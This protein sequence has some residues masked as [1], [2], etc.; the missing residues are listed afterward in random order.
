MTDVKGKKVL[1]MGL[2]RFGGGVGVTK[3]LVQKG[4]HVTITDL[5]TAQ[6]LSESVQ[7]LKGLKLKWVLGQHDSRDVK[8]ADL[9]VVNPA[10]KPDSPYLK[11]ASKWRV[12]ITTEI[13]LFLERCSARVVGVTGTNGK[14]TVARMIYSILA[15]NKKQVTGNRKVWLGGNIGKSLLPEL[16]KIK[17]NDIVV[18]ELS[19]FQLA[20]LPIIKKSP[21][22]TVIVNITPDHLDWHKTM[23]AY[24][25]AKRNILWFQDRNDFTVLNWRDKNVRKVAKGAKSNLVKIFR[26]VSGLKLKVQGEHN[27]MNATLAAEVGR[28]FG[29]QMSEIRNQLAH[30]SGVEYA[31]EFVGQRNGV[32]FY[33]DSAAT[34]PEATIAALNSFEQPVILI[35]GGYDKKINLKPFSRQIKHKF[36]ALLL[37]GQTGHALH[38]MVRGSVHTST[39]DRA[40]SL[41]KQLAKPGD[42]ILLSPAAAS[43]DQFENLEERGRRFKNLV[44][45]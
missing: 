23:R 37:I 36:K 29:V 43:Y 16:D 33:N 31:L 27:L 9:I 1:V 45:Q 24:L 32:K 2:G 12:P 40:V 8:N 21:Q 7:Q 25:D 10:V 5:K 17:P 28:L 19:S 11:M 20:W 44:L 18:L 38:R 41:A 3:W 22:V 39:L 42:I 34:T 6:Q 15:G 4:A 13:N 35:A 30:F 26:P 14:E